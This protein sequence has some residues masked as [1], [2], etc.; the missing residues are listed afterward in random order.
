MVMPR[1]KLW[2]GRFAKATDPLVEAFTESI[3]TDWRLFRHDILGSIAHARMLVRIG[4]LT[5]AE[6]AKI[7]K[8]LKTVRREIEHKRFR[9]ELSLEDIH[10]HVEARLV[11]LAG[12][13]GKKL[14]TG[15]SRN[16]QIAL[17]LRLFVRDEIVA[18]D[19]LLLGLE[20]ALLAL[21]A[22]YR[23]I[24]LPGYTHLQRAQP[25]SAV[26]YFLAYVEMFER[27]RGRLRDAL[28]R[29][30]ESPLGAG[31]L[32]G[33]R[34]PL[35]RAYVARLLK[36]DRVMPNTLDAVA[37]RDFA[38]EYVSALALLAV[39]ASRLA[40]E[41][42]LW[43]TREFGFL[44]IDDAF[45]TGSSM[46]PQKKNP[47]VLEIVR[48]KAGGFAGLLQ[49]LLMTM[50]GLPLAY[51]RD[52]QETVPPVIRASDAAR[53]VV[54]ILAAL[55]PNVRLVTDRIEAGLG[56]D[57]SESTALADELVLRGMPFRE[58]HRVV[59]KMVAEC[60]R[61]GVPLSGLGLDGIR[62][63]APRADVKALAV[64]SPRGALA[65]AQRRAP[66]CLAET[67]R[68]LLP[69]LRTFPGDL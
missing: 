27:D 15:R 46:M 22:R 40:E 30:N 2:G 50:K 21:A 23:A 69:A 32:A 24:I 54:G 59:G 68:R 60:V 36:F 3:S 55:A 43:A 12:A 35:D 14:H 8:G 58:A 47:D 20:K 49:S 33:S 11:E 16:D 65:G 38:V 67:R 10:T 17:D 48:G 44:E 62:R 31:A 19:R 9:F 53:A 4:I 56:G 28:A 5:R 34:I 37:D 45:C 52:L 1:K 42:V 39:H 25:V 7:E 29:V 13:A 61:R 66:A 63:H 64:L 57:F 18:L 41:W 26:M 6:G 51:N